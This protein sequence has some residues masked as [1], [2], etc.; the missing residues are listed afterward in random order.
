LRSFFIIHCQF[1]IPMLLSGSPPQGTVKVFHKEMFK[2]S[3]EA[4]RR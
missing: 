2:T 4:E 1:V 3:L